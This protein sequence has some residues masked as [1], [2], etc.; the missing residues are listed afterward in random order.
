L[1]GRRLFRLFLA[2]GLR[3]VQLSVQPEI[4][5]HGSP[6]FRPWVMN[7]IGNVRSGEKGL[8]ASGLSTA[9]EIDGA[10]G[11]LTSLIDRPDASAQFVW[12]R[13]AAVR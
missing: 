1:I 9:A 10:I 7:L 12:N 6:G 8:V 2:A 4:H 5:W 13:A 11:E 3:D